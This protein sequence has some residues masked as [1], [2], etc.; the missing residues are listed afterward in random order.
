MII[1]TSAMV[2]ILYGKKYTCR[3]RTSIALEL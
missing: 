3:G 2:A 1:D